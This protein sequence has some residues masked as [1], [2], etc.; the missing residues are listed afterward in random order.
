MDRVQLD[1]PHVCG[2]THTL[3]GWQTTTPGLVVFSAGPDNHPCGIV[4][5]DWVIFTHDGA[6]A[7]FEPNPDPETAMRRAADLG[8]RRDWTSGGDGPV[9]EDGW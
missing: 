3:T 6:V 2:E 4:A 7:D 8:G 5:D 1:V 9:V